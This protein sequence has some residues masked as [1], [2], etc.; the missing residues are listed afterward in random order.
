LK[1]VAESDD[2]VPGSGIGAKAEP[3]QGA[4]K[5]TQFL[6][7]CVDA[8]ACVSLITHFSSTS[9]PNATSLFL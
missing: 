2:G 7:F 1:A 9:S 3:M 5:Q 4:Q 6:C 8:L